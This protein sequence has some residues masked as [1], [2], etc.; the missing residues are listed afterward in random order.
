[1]TACRVLLAGLVLAVL[2][3]SAPSAPAPKNKGKGHATPQ[4]CYKAMR[5]AMKKSDFKTF[6]A[7]LTDDGQD[8]MAGQMLL[9]SSLLTSNMFPAE[10]GVD[11]K[12]QL[13]KILT[14]HKIS[15]EL[16]AK[17]QKEFQGGIGG[18]GYNEQMKKAKALSKHIKDKAGF[19]GDMFGVMMKA[20]PRP[21]NDKDLGELKDVKV[22]GAKAEGKL[23]TKPGGTEVEMKVTFAK[24]KNGWRMDVP[25]PKDSPGRKQ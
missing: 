1:M 3:S 25:V 24:D 21:N 20:M 10:K 11:V 6:V 14:K 12:G 15:K 17:V 22:T 5:A 19:A 2:I 9:M 23:I 13:E 8:M 4:E 7:C 18:G 16:L